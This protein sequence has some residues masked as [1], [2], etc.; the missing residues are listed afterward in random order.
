VQL[1]LSTLSDFVVIAN[2]IKLSKVVGTTMIDFWFELKDNYE[3][4]YQAKTSSI[5]IIEKIH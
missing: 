1:L 2:K 3:I 5:T 4:H